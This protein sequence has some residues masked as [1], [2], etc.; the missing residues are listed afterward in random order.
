MA[1]ARCVEVT[2]LRE[3]ASSRGEACSYLC[4]NVF[5]FFQQKDIPAVFDE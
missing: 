4:Y 5:S 1:A 2:A 3:T